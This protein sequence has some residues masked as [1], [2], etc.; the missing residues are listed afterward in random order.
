MRFIL[1]SNIIEKNI[2]K[3]L[4][5]IIE[6]SSEDINANSIRK[7]DGLIIRSLTKVNENLLIN[8]KIKFVGTVSSGFDHI[9]IE[10]L[11]K[12]NIYFASSCGRNANSVAEYVIASL[13]YLL[14]NRE[15]ISK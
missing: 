6:L 3:S 13:F 10:F 5:E 14:R 8:S 7:A 1:D 11:K 12:N 4:G 9:D 15:N 2:F